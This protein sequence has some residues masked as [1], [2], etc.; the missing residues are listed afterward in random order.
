MAIV[1]TP[2]RPPGPD[3]QGREEGL[4]GCDTRKKMLENIE[5]EIDQLPE[6]AVTRSMSRSVVNDREQP[7]VEPGTRDATWINFNSTTRQYATQ[8]K[9]QKPTRK[10]KKTDAF[11]A[12]Q[13]NGTPN[14]EFT[15][16]S[17]GHPN[18]LD[19]IAW[20]ITELKGI[21]AQQGQAVETLKTCCEELKADQKELI[22]Q[23]SSLKDEIT[24]LRTQ[25]THRPDQQSWASIASNGGM[26]GESSTPPPA[27][28]S[29]STKADRK[30][31]PL[32]VRIS[33]V[34][35]SDSMEYGG[36]LTRYLPVEEVKARV[37]DALQKNMPTE[38]VEIIGVGTTKTGYIIR[39]RDEA[40]KDTASVNGGW[41]RNLGSQTKLVRPRFGVVV[42]RTPTH[43]VDTEDKPQSMKKITEENELAQKGY[44]VEEIAWLKKRESTLGASASLGIWFDSAEAAEW[45]AALRHI[46]SRRNDATDAWPSATWPGTAKRDYDVV[47]VRESTTQLTALESRLL[48]AQTAQNATRQEQQSANREPMLP[49]FNVNTETADFTTERQQK[50]FDHR[51]T[52]Q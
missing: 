1:V 14:I 38:G 10:R 37:T 30:D 47:S 35:A 44:K 36:S 43:E 9:T 52:P 20:L 25:V 17:D 8:P 46:R 42:H 31:P 3:R 26:N 34:Q 22:R 16:N 6:A 48:N 40:S 12:V 4:Q 41:L 39:F 28:T 21:I 19:E 50:T 7:N 2:W 27:P 45:A 29:A 24:A 15:G 33:A 49:A 51:S 18:K 13:L 5:S 23:N 32:C 11:T